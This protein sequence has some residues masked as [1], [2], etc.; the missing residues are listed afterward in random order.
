VNKRKASPRRQCAFRQRLE[1]KV[2]YIIFSSSTPTER[3]TGRLAPRLET[4]CSEGPA[5]GSH[6]LAKITVEFFEGFSMS[7]LDANQ[8]VAEQI[9]NAGRF[10]GKAF[11]SGECVALL[12]GK[13]VAVANDLRAALRS[14]RTLD[15]DPQ[16]GMVFE[17]G[18]PVTDVIRG[19]RNGN[20][21]FSKPSRS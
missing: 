1:A 19:A 11:K 21:L 7:E 6:P 16:R 5:T 12:D 3:S 20:C 13:V 10:N 2:S 18:P 17:V 14:L 9:C 4:S 15:A 8:Q